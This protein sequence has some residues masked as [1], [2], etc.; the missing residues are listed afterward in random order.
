[1]ERLNRS[2]RLASEDDIYKMFKIAKGRY[3][4][5][6]IN[7]PTIKIPWWLANKNIF[8]LVEDHVG[9][10]TS[11]LNILPL[12][13][14]CYANLRAGLI[15]E[16]EIPA[17][18]ILDD[19]RRS[20]T[21]HLYVEGLNCLRKRDMRYLLTN[22]VSF[23]NLLTEQPTNEVLI[24][25]YGGTSEGIKLLTRLNFTPLHDNSEEKQFFETNLSN[26]T[27]EVE[28]LLFK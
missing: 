6:R 21:R 2:V 7:G 20:E 23:T 10:I 9:N 22:F 12:T 1:M 15:T 17:N 14:A 27:G 5:S 16:K 28:K 25:A 19:K 4:E 8:L 24:G 18:D 3:E 11:N 26:L 13:G